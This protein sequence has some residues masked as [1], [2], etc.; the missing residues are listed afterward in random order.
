M[1]LNCFIPALC[2]ELV[3]WLIGT[4]SSCLLLLASIDLNCVCH[5]IVPFTFLVFSSNVVVWGPEPLGDEV[6]SLVFLSYL[7]GT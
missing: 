4:P 7:Y 3:K 6:V 1:L 5:G 2:L